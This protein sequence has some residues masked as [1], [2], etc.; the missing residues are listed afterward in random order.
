MEVTPHLNPDTLLILNPG[1]GFSCT[2]SKILAE[3]WGGSFICL[4]ANRFLEDGFQSNHLPPHVYL[5]LKLWEKTGC[6]SVMCAFGQNGGM[7]QGKYSDTREKNVRKKYSASQQ[8]REDF[9]IFRLHMVK[10]NNVSPEGGLATTPWWG[11]AG[12]LPGNCHLASCR[13][14]RH[15]SSDALPLP[16]R[17]QDRPWPVLRRSWAAWVG[18]QYVTTLRTVVSDLTGR[19][20]TVGAG[21]VGNESGRGP[22]RQRRAL[23]LASPS[24]LLVTV[25]KGN[26]PGAAVFQDPN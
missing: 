24:M 26:L 22:A 16:N 25:F 19:V 20:A 18:S 6:T 23:A 1:R 3:T 12:E 10:T 14:D 21:A 5:P 9:S 13:C 8:K 17:R 11:H 15:D 4:S 7:N 2:L